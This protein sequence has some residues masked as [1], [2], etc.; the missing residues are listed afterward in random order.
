MDGNIFESGKKK[1]ADSKIAG[2]RVDGTLVII[3]CYRLSMSSIIDKNRSIKG[4]ERKG[5]ELI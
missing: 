5:K 3:D 4:K 2:I 1:V